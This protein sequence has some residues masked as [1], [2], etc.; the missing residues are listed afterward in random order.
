MTSFM[1]RFIVVFGGAG[2]Y[3]S[4]LK[5]RETFDDLQIWD[6]H[7]A[8]LYNQSLLKR[9]RDDSDYEPSKWIDMNDQGV[10]SPVS[11]KK[12]QIMFHARF[13]KTAYTGGIN[14]DIADAGP[15]TRR[16]YHAAEI[17]G[18]CLVVQGGLYCEDNRVLDDFALYDIA[19]GMWIEFK[20]PKLNRAAHFL[21]PRSYHSMTSVQDPNIS[22]GTRNSR[23][24]W[25]YEPHHL[26]EGGGESRQKRRQTFFKTSGLF[27]FGGLKGHLT[28]TDPRTMA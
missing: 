9:S 16:C 17:Y 11:P 15:P 8:E 26:A 13:D 4:K 2:N 24:M 28:V 7:N 10:I 3:M 21:G 22:L 6:A 19:L 27:V 5:R 12:F 20:Q 1:D 18:G 25:L 14:R 23:L